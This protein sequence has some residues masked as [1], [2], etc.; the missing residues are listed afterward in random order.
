M[1]DGDNVESG[2][3]MGE[4]RDGGKMKQKAVSCIYTIPLNANDYEN[5]M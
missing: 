1:L 2:R 3:G 5:Q 4:G